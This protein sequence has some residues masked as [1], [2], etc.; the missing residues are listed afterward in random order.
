MSRPIL[1]QDR[2]HP[3]IRAQLDGRHRVVQEVEAAVAAHAVVVVGMGLNPHPGRAR[4]LLDSLSI[5][6]HDLD[7]GSYLSQWRPRLALKMWSGW[8]TF[9][10]IFVQGVLIGGADHLRAL[11]ASGELAASLAA[12][13]PLP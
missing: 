7:Y 1:E 12:K 2:L 8:P 10:M 13:R 4:K 5:A 9:P 3:A 6:H 11:A